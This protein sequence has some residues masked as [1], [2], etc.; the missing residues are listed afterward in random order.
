MKRE[1]DMIVYEK[2]GQNMEKRVPAPPKMLAL[3]LTEEECYLVIKSLDLYSRIWIGQGILDIP[4]K[5]FRKTRR[6]AP[7][8]GV[9]KLPGAGFLTQMTGREHSTTDYLLVWYDEGSKT[10]FY[11]AGEDYV[12]KHSGKLDL[13]E[14]IRKYIRNKCYATGGEDHGK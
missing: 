9:L 8:P 1:T 11:Y 4:F 10:E 12:I 5:H 3:L 2:N 7:P 13:P 14:D 6:K